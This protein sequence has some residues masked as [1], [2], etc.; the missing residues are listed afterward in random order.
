M[1]E[2]PLTHLHAP[3][4]GNKPLT[5]ARSGTDARRTGSA[6][7]R[8]G[9][10][11]VLVLPAAPNASDAP[12]PRAP[13]LGRRGPA[14]HSGHVERADPLRRFPSPGPADPTLLPPGLAKE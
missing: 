9:G 13:E 14:A 11:R 7:A 4:P 2:F 8:R 1:V 5:R 12:G 6:R 10:A 3:L